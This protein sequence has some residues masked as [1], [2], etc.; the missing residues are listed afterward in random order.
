MPKHAAGDWNTADEEATRVVSPQETRVVSSDTAE[1]QPVSTGRQRQQ[2]EPDVPVTQ[3]MRRAPQQQYQ[4]G[5]QYGQQYQ[6]QPYQAQYQQP[7]GQQ[8]DYQQ[9]YRPNV[10]PV[11]SPAQQPFLPSDQG[12][13]REQRQHAGGA[14]IA[15]LLR[16]VAIVLRLC[17]IALSALVVANAFNIGPLRIRLVEITSTV[18]SWIPGSLSG[19]LV[20]Q[21]PFGGV[22]RG[23]FVA[24]AVAFF[25]VDWLL[26]R[27]ARELR[28]R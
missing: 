7:Y 3:T 19:S 12:V 27:K 1:Y 10:A 9:A 23:D 15:W 16:L 5:G 8:P 21:T 4:Q 25:V 11:A 22:L 26:S 28:D 24:V 17:A 6:Q 13:R 2:S 20:Y 18:A 14:G